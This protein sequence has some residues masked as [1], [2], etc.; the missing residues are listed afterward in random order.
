MANLVPQGSPREFHR[1]ARVLLA[2]LLVGVLSPLAATADD[3]LNG[4]F[5]CWVVRGL[6]GEQLTFCEWAGDG[7]SGRTNC[8]DGPG[9]STDGRTCSNTVVGGHGG[10]GGGGGDSA[11]TIGPGA[12][13]PPECQT[14]VRQLY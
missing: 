3:Y 11:C 5:V 14:C 8:S 10:G 4:C 1:T 6:S 7:L 12:W 9:C 13:C 2:I